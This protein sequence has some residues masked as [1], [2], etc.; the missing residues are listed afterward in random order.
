MNPIRL[1]PSVSRIAAVGLLALAVA[2]AY[3][4]LLHGWFVAPLRAID[5]Q[6]ET[7]RDT[8][9]RYAAAIAEKP[10]LLK[11]IAAQGTGNTDSRAFLP[12]DDPGSAAADLM[13]RV[14]DA[15]AAQRVGGGCVVTQKMPVTD[16]PAR[17]SEP[18]RAVAV[19]VNLRCDIQPLVGV[20][21]ALQQGTPSLFVDNIGIYR[22][23]TARQPGGEQPSLD[24]Q[25][26]VS[27]YLRP[28]GMA[29]SPVP[30]MSGDVR[31]M[32]M[33]GATP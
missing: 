1:S 11:R 18:Y 2:L 17:A 6:M 15:V 7:L 20:L 26:A 32:R 25:L 9:S 27:G 4:V 28:A 10:Q 16:L 24:V 12:A 5:A 30:D 13:R 31:T 8:Q 23:P 21:Q 3:C 22:N 14:V 29:P 33:P 19:N